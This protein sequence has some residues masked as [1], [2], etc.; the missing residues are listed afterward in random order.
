MKLL[1][2]VCCVLIIVAGCGPPPSN[3]VHVL[4]AM[5]TR[6]A[7]E[8][9]AR[10]F[11]EATGVSVSIN[12]ASSSTL[13]KQIE[14]G[15]DADL[16]LSADKAWADYLEKRGLAAERRDLLG[17]RLVV[18]TPTDIIAK[19]DDLSDLKAEKFQHIA[20]GQADVP[21]GAY[22]RQALEKA[23]VWESVRKRIVEAGDVRAVLNYVE[24]G[25]AEAGFVYATDARASAKVRVAYNVPQKLHEPIRYP[26][27]RLKSDRD[28]PG[29]R[30]FYDYLSG[31]AARK[32]FEDAGFTVLG[33]R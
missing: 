28:N 32:H 17:N 13:A 2:F 10:D 26:L 25:E 20:L 22:A 29:V 8:S 7:V 1:C 4:V 5:S 11:K 6:D 24:R 12:G 31:D 9:V 15:A 27:V 3:K 21:A 19:F 14:N 30:R 33:S 23:G 18:I 16:F